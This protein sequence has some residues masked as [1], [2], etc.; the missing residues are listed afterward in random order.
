[1]NEYLDFTNNEIWNQQ[2]QQQ[3]KG[4]DIFL[5]SSNY[6]ENNVKIWM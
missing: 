2:Q 4:Q 5:S 1:M 3:W 6:M